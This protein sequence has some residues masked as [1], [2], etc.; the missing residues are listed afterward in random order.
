VDG[1]DEKSVTASSVEEATAY[2]DDTHVVVQQHQCLKLYDVGVDE[3]VVY[4]DLSLDVRV[5]AVR[6]RQHFDGHRPSWKAV[7]HVVRAVDD[8]ERACSPCAKV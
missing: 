7:S 1:S 4:Q 8:T 5:L 3:S 2:H 6:P